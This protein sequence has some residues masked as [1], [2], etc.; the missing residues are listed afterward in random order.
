VERLDFELVTIGVEIVCND[1][2]I[3]LSLMTTLTTDEMNDYLAP[4]SEQDSS[5]WIYI[6][7]NNIF[8]LFVAFLPSSSIPQYIPTSY[9]H[10]SFKVQLKVHHCPRTFLL[11]IKLANTS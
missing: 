11:L 10:S 8:R 4:Q 2:Q 3:H 6:D 9:S 5:I 1:L 7:Y